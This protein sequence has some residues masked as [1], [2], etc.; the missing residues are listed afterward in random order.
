LCK[1]LKNHYKLK[2]SY[3]KGEGSLLEKVQRYLTTILGFTLKDTK[4]WGDL[5]ISYRIRNCI[6]HKDSFL[7]LED[8]N[9]LAI[10]D[11]INRTESIMLDDGWRVNI[12]SSSLERMIHLYDAM[13]KDICESWREWVEKREPNGEK[14]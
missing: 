2:Q 13:N 12:G 6:V 10:K 1:H 8:K 9:N 5:I 14:E 3:T 11:F 4:V 7:N